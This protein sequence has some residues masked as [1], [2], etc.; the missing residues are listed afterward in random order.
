MSD[1]HASLDL[2]HLRKHHPAPE[3]TTTPTPPP[4]AAHRPDP[5]TRT[6]RAIRQANIDPLNDPAAAAIARQRI[7]T[8]HDSH[9]ITHPDAVPAAPTASLIT[10]KDRLAARRDLAPSTTRRKLPSAVAPLLTAI[11]IFALVLLLF[12]APIIISQVSYAMSRPS[13]SPTATTTSATSV[14][15]STSTITIPK[16]NVHAPVEYIDSV[17]EADVQ[18]ALQDGVVHYGTTALPGK[19]GN[20]AIF[21]HSS[22]DWCEPVNFKFVFVLLDKLSPG[23]QITLDYQSVRYTYE[24]TGSRIVDPTAVDVLNPHPR[25]LSLSSLAAHSERRLSAS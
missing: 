4:P 23:D 21:C 6:K 13:G 1:D 7:A 25:Q 24:V 16:I 10:D 22:N 11:G 14:I 17:Q 3:P 19:N 20:V 5:F 15:P 12:K 18:R 2:Q 8:L 9:P